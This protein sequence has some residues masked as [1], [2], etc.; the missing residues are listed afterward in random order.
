MNKKMKYYSAIWLISLAI[1]N[2]VAFITPSA[3]NGVSKYD[4]S[5]W[6]GYGFITATFIGQLACAYKA[7]KSN[8]LQRLFYNVSLISV[9]YIG[10]IVM[11]I[12]GGLCMAVPQMPYWI[13]V[14]ACLLVFGVT[15]I[16]VIKTSAAIEI[17]ENIDERIKE[18]TFFIKSLTVDADGLVALAKTAEMKVCAKSIYEAIRY[19][20]PMENP[21]LT[22]VEAQIAS[23]FEEFSKAVGDDNIA[24]AKD[25]SNE[26]LLLIRNRN[27]KC[28]LLK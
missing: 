23:K 28:K 24:S 16:A 7:F 10:L 17:V 14:I 18:Q 15:A 11:L 25:V 6:I 26:L 1:F 2:A 22:N 3:V 20:D 5:F 27:Q 8:S 19:S 13:G 12:V 21:A 4:A 9:S